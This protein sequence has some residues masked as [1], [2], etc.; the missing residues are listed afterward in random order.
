MP[1]RRITASPHKDLPTTDV[2][3]T[4]KQVAQ[5]V[6]KAAD[7]LVVVHAVLD[8]ELAEEVRSDDVDQAVAQTAKIEKR[9]SKSA[10][11]LEEVNRKLEGKVSAGQAKPK[12]KKR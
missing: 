12:G 4:N 3:Q 9:L 10:K 7:D 8:K 11:A 6:K 1:A 2:V 5:E